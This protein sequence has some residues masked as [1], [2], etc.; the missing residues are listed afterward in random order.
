MDYFGHEHQVSK[1]DDTNLFI[2]I[3]TILTA[4]RENPAILKEDV[5]DMEMN[6]NNLQGAIKYTSQQLCNPTSL[7][8]MLVS[9]GFL[10][11]AAKQRHPLSTEIDAKFNLV[12]IVPVDP[13]GLLIALSLVPTMI[14]LQPKAN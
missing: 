7:S 14:R 6:S 2:I 3:I 13:P 9:A 12:E 11:C 5:L 8:A 4:P 10:P 1:F